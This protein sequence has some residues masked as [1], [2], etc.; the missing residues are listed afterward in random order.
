VVQKEKVFEG[1]DFTSMN[2]D[3]FSFNDDF[4]LPTWTFDNGW[5]DP[6]L[7]ESIRTLT[8]TC[9]HGLMDHRQTISSTPALSIAPVLT[10][11]LHFSPS[12]PAVMSGDSAFTNLCDDP[13]V[14]FHPC[15]LRFVP[16]FFWGSGGYTF[17]KLVRDFFQRKNSANT[18]FLHKLYNA[19]K[20]AEF[21]PYYA[22]F[23]G[24]QWLNE[25]VIRVNKRRFARLIGIKAI[26]GALFHQQGNFP[27][28][29]FVELGPANSG[30]YVA[31][32]DLKGIDF[33]DIR[34]FAHST[35]DFL[36]SSTPAVFEKCPWVKISSGSKT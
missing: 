19:L 18:R 17:G 32:D 12:P 5:N 35:G 14:T 9:D 30:P 10:N 28:H 7:A 22:D 20:I 33:D 8:M 2:A 3:L 13:T 15:E 29:G 16:T 1:N 11:P 21:D 31:R 4:D 24:V 26:D 36:R 27:T 23:V 6:P 34:L 25:K